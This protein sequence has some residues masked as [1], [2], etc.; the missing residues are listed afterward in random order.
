M[1]RRPYLNFSIVELEKIFEQSRT[2]EDVLLKLLGEL[3][4]R[5]TDRAAR[6]LVSVSETMEA[7]QK[8][9]AASTSPGVGTPAA[10]GTAPMPKAVPQAAGPASAEDSLGNQ[11]TGVLSRSRFPPPTRDRA[12]DILSAWIALEVLSP[13]TYRKP[14]DIA[15]GDERRVA[16]FEKTLPPP[17]AGEGEKSR[18]NRRLFYQ[19]VLGVIRMED[20]T[21][22]L[23]D[24]F[25][26]THGDRQPAQGFAPIATITVDKSGRPSDEPAVAISSFAWGLPFALKGDLRALDAWPEA[27]SRLVE[28]LDQKVRVP[29]DDGELLPLDIAVIERAHNWLVRRLGLQDKMVEQPSPTSPTGSDF[30]DFRG[31]RSR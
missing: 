22:A 28:S 14:S 9:R 17:W 1:A 30:C 2:N 13:Q 29:G 20:A 23:F 11:A 31:V 21:K 27:E 5:S 7:A 6:L 26:D 15:D 10:Y 19:I 8:L 4:Q 24:A 16:R 3:R 25:V 18:P 12:E